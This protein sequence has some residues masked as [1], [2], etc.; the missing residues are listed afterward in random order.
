M[1]GPVGSRPNNHLNSTAVKALVGRCPHG[2][3]TV[4]AHGHDGTAKSGVEVEDEPLDDD[5]AAIVTRYRA[6]GAPVTGERALAAAHAVRAQCPWH[7][8]WLQGR[9]AWP[10]KRRAETMQLSPT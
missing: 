8:P 2:G 1:S 9:R 7:L 5:G 3:T 4:V 10:Y 6:P